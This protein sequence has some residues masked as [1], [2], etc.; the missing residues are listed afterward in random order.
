MSSL[1]EIR[2]LELQLLKKKVLRK[3]IVL[4][5]EKKKW[6]DRAQVPIVF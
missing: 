3:E 5:I 4:V 1:C 2:Y 6:N